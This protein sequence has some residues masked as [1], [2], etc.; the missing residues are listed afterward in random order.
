MSPGFQTYPTPDNQPDTIRVKR[1]LR[2][3]HAE[4]TSR[5][6]ERYAKLGPET[7]RSCPERVCAAASAL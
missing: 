6:D 7:A 3:T 4:N 5:T 2:V 1:A